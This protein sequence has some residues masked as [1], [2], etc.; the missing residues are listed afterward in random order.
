MELPHRER[1]VSAPTRR[2]VN[3]RGED[4]SRG[5]H[6]D[7]H[8]PVNKSGILARVDGVLRDAAL[9]TQSQDVSIPVVLI[10]STRDALDSSATAEVSEHLLRSTVS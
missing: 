1:P 3:A 6:G 7:T 10:S 5:M 2:R 4:R 8:Q 9:G